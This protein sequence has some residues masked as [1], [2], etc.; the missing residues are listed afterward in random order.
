[1]EQDAATRGVAKYR[2]RYWTKI[3]DVRMCEGRPHPSV[4]LEESLGK[5]T[6]E[7]ERR[8]VQKRTNQPP[9]VECTTLHHHL[10]QK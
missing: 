7:V 2:T 1:M 3:I 5:S 8:G 4:C 9:E 6:D 10:R